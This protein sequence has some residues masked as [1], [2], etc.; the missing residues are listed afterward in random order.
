MRPE[1]FLNGVVPPDPG[2][3]ENAR[4]IGWLKRQGCGKSL[5]ICRR[6]ADQIKADLDAMLM[7]DHDK[8]RVVTARGEKMVHLA[9]PVWAD[10]WCSSYDVEVPH[11]AHI[12]KVRSMK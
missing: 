5:A 2:S 11:H 7:L 8:I 12:A 6:K 1:I 9:D 10:Q 3:L 4:F